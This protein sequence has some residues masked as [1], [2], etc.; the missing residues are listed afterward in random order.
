MNDPKEPLVYLDFYEGEDMQTI[1][2]W[3][4]D[5]IGEASQEFLSEEEAL[6]ARTNNEL[7]WS[8]LSDLGE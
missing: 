1:W 7:I 4:K 5:T 8:R 2:C 3:K 6:A